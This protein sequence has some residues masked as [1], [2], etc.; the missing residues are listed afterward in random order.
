MNETSDTKG[1]PRPGDAIHIPLK[2]DEALRALLKVK[3][4]ADMPRPGT[5]KKAHAPDNKPATKK[6]PN[7]SKR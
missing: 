6:N 1:V 4:T 7:G 2:T 3:P 5:A